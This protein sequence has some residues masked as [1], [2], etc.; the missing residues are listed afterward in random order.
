VQRYKKFCEQLPKAKD[1][2]QQL[3]DSLDQTPVH[4]R[5][6][7]VQQLKEEL[8]SMA[9]GMGPAETSNI[10]SQFQFSV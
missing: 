8:Q 9:Q 10:W 1:D 5:Q 3:L 6:Q 4:E 7:L 2:R